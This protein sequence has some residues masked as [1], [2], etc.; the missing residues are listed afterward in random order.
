MEVLVAA[1][2]QVVEIG[3]R[4]HVLAFGALLG[5]ELFGLL[6]VLGHLNIIIRKQGNEYYK[7]RGF[8]TA[9]TAY[10]LMIKGFVVFDRIN[11]IFCKISHRTNLRRVSSSVS[12]SSLPI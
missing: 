7:K 11:S 9:I 10:G 8:E 6:I 12:C 1:G 2:A 4:V 5:I 3:M